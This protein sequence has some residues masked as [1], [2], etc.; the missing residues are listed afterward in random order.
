MARSADWAICLA[1]T[2]PDAAKHRGISYFLVDMA[3]PGIEIRPLREITG[4]A[5]FNEVFLDEVVVPEDCL[6]GQPGDGWRIARSTLAAE[7]TAMGGGSGSA[8]RWT[9]CSARSA[10]AGPDGDP[11]SQSRSAGWSPAGWPGRCW[12]SGPPWQSWTA[13]NRPAAACAS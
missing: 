11:A 5:M 13:R 9:H 6:L 7:R 10:P 12:T 2:D 4:R 1:R 3:S 8:T